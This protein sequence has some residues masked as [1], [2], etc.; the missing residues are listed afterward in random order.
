[1]AVEK[2]WVFHTFDWFR[3]INIFWSI[4]LSKTVEPFLQSILGEINQQTLACP[5][6]SI[7]T[8]GKGVR[9]I[10]S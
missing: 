6:S 5:N 2:R 10:Q 3:D 1:M 7:E 4:T 8:V 9:Y